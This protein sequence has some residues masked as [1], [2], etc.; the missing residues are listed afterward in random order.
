GLCVEAGH[1]AA[2]PYSYP[3]PRRRFACFFFPAPN[4]LLLLDVSRPPVQNRRRQHVVKN[5][6]TWLGRPIRW[7]GS[8]A[9]NANV[10]AR[11]LLQQRGDL[12]LGPVGVPSEGRN[13]MRDRRCGGGPEGR[14]K[15]KILVGI[16]R[17]S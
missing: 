15:W 13:R 12:C 4:P 17:S 10:V 9:Q 3:L 11:E 14:G 7:R 2:T 8:R 5:L 16:W 1:H 6:I